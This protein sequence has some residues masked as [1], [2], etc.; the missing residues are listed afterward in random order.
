[1]KCKRAPGLALIIWKKKPLFIFT[2]TH[3]WY[4][5]LSVYNSIDQAYSC[6]G[7]RS[8]VFVWFCVC[9]CV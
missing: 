7:N 4:K 1:M 3:S 8:L 5:F 6:R 9:M 2:R